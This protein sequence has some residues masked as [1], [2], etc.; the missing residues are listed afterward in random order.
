M[1][2][3]RRLRRP[4]VA[5]LRQT[6]GMTHPR[7]LPEHKLATPGSV[8]CSPRRPKPPPHH[9]SSWGRNAV[10]RVPSVPQIRNAVANLP[11]SHLP[12]PRPAGLPGYSLC[13]CGSISPSISLLSGSHTSPEVLTG[14]VRVAKIH[15]GLPHIEPDPPPRPTYPVPGLKERNGLPGPAAT[16]HQSH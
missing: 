2:T 8:R 4:C 11:R 3:G 6:W 13:G 15:V 10:S 7:A 16:E 14:A 9:L 5:A 12:P 1:H